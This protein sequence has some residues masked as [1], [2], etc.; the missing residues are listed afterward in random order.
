MFPAASVQLYHVS[1]CGGRSECACCLLLPYLYLL[2][3]SSAVKTPKHQ[4]TTPPHLHSFPL[5]LSHSFYPIPPIHPLMLCACANLV[6]AWDTIL[7]LLIAACHV[8]SDWLPA[9]TVAVSLLACARSSDRPVEGAAT[10]R[11]PYTSPLLLLPAPSDAGAMVPDRPH[12]PRSYSA[13][14][15]IRRHRRSPSF[16]KL[17]TASESTPESPAL[18]LP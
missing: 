4:N 18:F 11:M 5:S 10:A 3:P 12:L 6:P 1:S 9:V 17:A 7:L 14:A 13:Q 15:Y 16:S 8:G 2:A